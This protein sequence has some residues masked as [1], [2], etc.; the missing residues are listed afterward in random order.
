MVPKTILNKGRFVDSKT[1]DSETEG[2]CRAD[3]SKNVGHNCNGEGEAGA[4]PEND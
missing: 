3:S 1:D 4:A 2:T